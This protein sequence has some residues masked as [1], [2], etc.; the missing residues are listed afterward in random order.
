MLIFVA[1][2]L[3]KHIRFLTVQYSAAVCLPLTLFLLPSPP[4]LATEQLN[5]TNVCDTVTRG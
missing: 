4:D 3:I 2:V 5:Q 1:L